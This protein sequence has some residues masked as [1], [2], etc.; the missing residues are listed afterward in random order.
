M[1]YSM[2][3]GGQPSAG[4]EGRAFELVEPATGMV[5]AEVAQAGPADVDEAVAAA[6]A[7]FETGTWAN[8][9]ATARGRA[10]PRGRA[11]A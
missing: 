2:L 10:G 6:T 4:H 8:T 9:S 7:A 1:R 11:A 5:M 3:I